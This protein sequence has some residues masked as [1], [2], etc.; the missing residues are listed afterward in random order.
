M[1]YRNCPIIISDNA[2][3]RKSGLINNGLQVPESVNNIRLLIPI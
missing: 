1:F 3:S 2:E